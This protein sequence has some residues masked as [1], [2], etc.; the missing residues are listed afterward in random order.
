MMGKPWL[1][2]GSCWLLPSPGIPEL[3]EAPAYWISFTNPALLP[4]FHQRRQFGFRPQQKLPWPESSNAGPR[5]SIAR[6]LQSPA[7]STPPFAEQFPLASHSPNSEAW[8]MRILY[9]NNTI[10]RLAEPKRTFST[11]SARWIK[12]GQEKPLLFSNGFMAALPAFR[13]P[14]VI[15]FPAH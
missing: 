7:E 8:I 6:F 2:K 14:S 12:R 15:A 3:V 13:R 5:A 11:S 4:D 9:C 1:T 10:I